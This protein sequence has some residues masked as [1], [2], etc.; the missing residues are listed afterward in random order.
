MGEH[1][2]CCSPAKLCLWSCV[3]PDFLPWCYTG[4]WA[5]CS[6]VLVLPLWWPPVCC[7]SAA[8][9]NHN[10]DV[11]TT[12]TWVHFL[13]KM[14]ESIM[15]QDMVGVWFYFDFLK[16]YINQQG[17]T[18]ISLRLQRNCWNYF[19]PKGVGFLIEI[20]KK[21]NKCS[22]SSVSGPLAHKSLAVGRRKAFYQALRWLVGQK[23]CWLAWGSGNISCHVGATPSA[24]LMPLVLPCLLLA[25]ISLYIQCSS[26][27]QV[28]FHISWQY[29]V[30]SQREN[31]FPSK[32]H[33]K[34]LKC[35]AELASVILCWSHQWLY[36]CFL[37]VWADSG[38]ARKQWGCPL[39]AALA[40]LA[41]LT[42]LRTL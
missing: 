15:P 18:H 28:R 25:E 32:P 42:C 6:D 7:W 4:T 17:G 2:L 16:S 13:H 22:Q 26:V 40:K 8:A 35:F 23:Q 31:C 12:L 38:E 10:L 34:I 9:V 29:L 24:I 1:S 19:F 41:S 39:Q 27:E 5:H 11:S 30:T 14:E 36:P 33:P 3:G 20:K 37:T 21:E